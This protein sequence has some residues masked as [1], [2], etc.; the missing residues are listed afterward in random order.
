MKPRKDV[1]KITR[2]REVIRNDIEGLIVKKC[3]PVV[4]PRG[5][6]TEAYNPNWGISDIPLV[7]AYYATLRPG[8]IKGWVMHKLQD[9]R[10]FVLNG[11]QH[12]AFFDARST[13]STYKNLV[14]I[15]ISERNRSL[16]IIP[17]MVFHA[18]KNVGSNDTMFINHP[19]KAYDRKNP[20]KYRLPV[21]NDLIPYD[22]SD[23]L[24][25]NY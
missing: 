23:T 17:K 1:Q 25:N 5:E 15:T 22:F 3:D 10:I 19:T 21:K 8:V 9:D 20:D 2:N 18:V 16:I 12:W 13:S 11:V 14:K 24:S 4:D 7:F 6:L